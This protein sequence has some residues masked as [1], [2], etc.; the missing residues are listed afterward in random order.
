ML[1]PSA[2]DDPLALETSWTPAAAGG[3]SFGTHRLRQSSVHRVEF[4]ASGGLRLF[5]LVFVL[6]GLGVLAW[7]LHRFDLDQMMLSNPDTFVP[8]LAGVVFVGAGIGM[9]W[10]GSTPRVFDKVRAM[11]WR[12]RREPAAVGAPGPD[13]APLTA[14]HALQLVSERITGKNSYT[15]YELNLVLSDASR[16]NVVD[17]GNLEQLRADARTLGQF[18]GKPVWDAIG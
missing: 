17:H 1:D 10:F 5:C 13:V 9:A 15:S 16:I 11:Y 7:H 3:A 14:I 18:L 12:G 2:F 4:A 8:L 6:A